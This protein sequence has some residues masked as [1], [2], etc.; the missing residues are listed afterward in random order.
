[1]ICKPRELTLPLFMRDTNYT[2]E[3]EAIVDRAT[4]SL[5][6]HAVTKVL[7]KWK[8]RPPEDN[9]WENFADF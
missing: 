9:T 3:L 1:M 4:V 5:G 7:I 6:R 2:P 8:A